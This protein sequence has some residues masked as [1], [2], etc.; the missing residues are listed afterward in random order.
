[1]VVAI[2]GGALALVQQGIHIERRGTA[3]GRD[4][5]KRGLPLRDIGAVLGLSVWLVCVLLLLP[6]GL[7]AVRRARA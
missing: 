6:V 4:P 2:G 3:H 5:N 1:M 7:V